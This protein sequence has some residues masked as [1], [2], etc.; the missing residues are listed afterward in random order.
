MNPSYSKSHNIIIIMI[1]GGRREVSLTLNRLS[2][3][4]QTMIEMDSIPVVREDGGFLDILLYLPMV[5]RMIRVVVLVKLHSDGIEAVERVEHVR[6]KDI[7][8]I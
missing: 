2:Q 6:S 7:S 4:I 3:L 8:M 1:Q 5:V